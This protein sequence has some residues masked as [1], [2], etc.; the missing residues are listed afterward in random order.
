[1]EWSDIPD[2]AWAAAGALI[3]AGLTK[4]Y[5]WRALL[6]TDPEVAFRDDLLATIAELRQENRQ[7][8]Q[9]IDVLRGGRG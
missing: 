2:A 4:T 8:R 6:R 7:L 5:E 1:V 3:V 9:E